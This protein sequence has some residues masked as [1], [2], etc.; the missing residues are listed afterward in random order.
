MEVQIRTQK[1]HDEAEFGIAAHWVYSEQRSRWKNFL[2]FNRKNNERIPTEELAWV[3]QLREWQNELGKDNEEFIE[4]L[5]IEFFKNHI[6]AFTPTGDV[7][8]LP[9][10]ATPIDFAYKVHS[11]IGNRAIGAKADQ[12][13]VPLDYKIKNGEV[14]EIITSKGFGKGP[15]PDWLRFVRTSIAKSHIKKCTRREGMLTI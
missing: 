12:R 15:S 5:K 3:K 14:I 1:M 6:F 11:E 7:I 4:G 8:E 9:E 13:I 10:D 2:R